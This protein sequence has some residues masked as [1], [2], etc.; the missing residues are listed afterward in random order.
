MAEDMRREDFS[1]GRMDWLADGQDKSV[2]LARMI[3]KPGKCSPAH[4]HS[5]CNEVI[6]VVSGGPAQRRA[7]Q[8][9]KMSSGDTLTIYAG[10]VHQT[11]NDTDNDVELVI[12][13][14]N[15]LRAYEEVGD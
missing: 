1:W 15:G 3:V 14:S 2:S 11:L 13:Y 7:D 5:N 10:E 6:H 9:I 4:R 8:W 12:A